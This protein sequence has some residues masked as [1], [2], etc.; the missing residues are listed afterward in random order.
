MKRRTMGWGIAMALC[1][2]A[3]A[4]CGD[5]DSGDGS[6]NDDGAA[7]TPSGPTLNSSSTTSNAAAP[8]TAIAATGE[9]YYAADASSG[10]AGSGSASRAAAFEPSPDNSTERYDAVGTNPFVLTESDAFSTFAADVDTASY[11]IFRRD[12][13]N[14]FLPVPDS[15]RLE[16][17]VN[18]FNY[19]YPAPSESDEHPFAITL[20]AAPSIFDRPTA[21]LRVGIQAVKPPPFEKKPTNLVFLIDTSGSMQSADKLPLVKTL[22]TS[23]LDVLDADDTV[24][25]VTYAGS[26][27][28]ALAPT[29]VSMRATIEATIDNFAAGG[30]TAGAAG[31][32]L[33][34]AQASDAFIEGGINHVVLCTDG[35]FNVGPSSDAELVA[36]IEE[37]R[38]SGITLTALGF[39]LGNLN[40]SMMEKVSNAGNGIYSVITSETHARRYAES[41]MLATLVHVARDMKIQVEFNPAAVIAYR[42]LGYENR[43]IADTAFRDDSVDAG[44]VGAGHRVTA[45]YELVLEGQSIP[46][47][48]GAPAAASGALD[49]TDA[50]LTPEID[51]ADL[52]LVKV[53]Y[54]SV[55]DAIDAPALETSQSLAITDL[56]A[57]HTDLD[58]DFQWALAIAAFAEVLKDSPFAD[59]ALLDSAKPIFETQAGSDPDRQELLTLFEQTLSLL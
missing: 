37:K 23:S 10:T 26:T 5:T 56:A 47:P 17:Y 29:P 46:M 11:D 58:G 59:L 45:L 55:D 51:A 20:A 21:V 18:Y 32:D 44:E 12:I 4:G 57:S 27:G 31:I 28:V 33:A 3:V 16:E 13:S 41:D 9:S 42:L 22:L 2:V 15:V 48:E 14:G 6:G 38:D 49:A 8:Q 24:S 19:D 36:L 50:A 30:S 40:D 7:P 39:G 54:R 35:D 1:A 34:Y 52:V 25:I 53:R 43:A